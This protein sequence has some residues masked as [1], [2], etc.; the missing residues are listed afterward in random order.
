MWKKNTDK[1]LR[2]NLLSQLLIV[3]VYLTTSCTQSSVCDNQRQESPHPGSGLHLITDEKVR[4][5]STPPLSGPH[6]SIAPTGGIWEKPIPPLQQVAFLE[7][8]GVIIH[9][10]IELK[11]SERLKLSS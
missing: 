9:Y 1:P 11:A 4:W 3:L 7:K 10:G 6:L 2:N 8:G 5:Q